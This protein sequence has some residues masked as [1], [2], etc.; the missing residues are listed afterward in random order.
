M[1]KI[2][3]LITAFV[4]IMSSL[5]FSASASKKVSAMWVCTVKNLDFPSKQGLSAAELKSE[6]ET[7]IDSAKSNGINTLFF[8]VRP[9]ADALYKSDIFPW[10]AV[11]S[12]TQ[13]KAPADNFDPLSYL[14]EI[15]HN[16]GIKVHA[17]INPYRIGTGGVEE[18][19]SALSDNNP[20]VL[21]PEYRVECSDGGVYF[22]PALPEVRTLIINGVLEIVQNYNVD[23]IHFDD[24]FY[25]YNVSDYP[26]S[27]DYEKYGADFDS[28]EDFRRNNI[29]T[30]VRDVYKAIKS[31]NPKVQFGI[32]P[33]GI[34]DNK[35]DNPDGSD[36]SGMSSYRSIYSDS[37]LWVQNGWLDYIC[38]QIYW[39]F[40]NPV[41][42]F[43]TLC[44]WWSELCSKTD[45]ELYIGIALYKVGTDEAGFENV[46][47]ITRQL[48]YLDGLSAVS[49]YSF[50]RS[51]NL[52]LLS[53][54]QYTPTNAY[55][56]TTLTITS[57]ENGYKTSSSDC[58]VSGV[59]DPGKKLTVNGKD[60]NMTLHGYFSVY[61]P[62]SVGSNEFTFLNGDIT[63][64][65]TIIRT[66]DTSAPPEMYNTC[67]EKDSAFPQGKCKF[68]SG[69]SVTFSVNALKDADVYAK[70]GDK[71]VQLTKTKETD[72]LA[73]F[74]ASVDIPLTAVG[75]MNAGKVVFYTDFKGG[76]FEYEAG[77]ITVLTSDIPLY[78]LS[79][80]YVYD[81]VDGGSMMDNFQLSASSEVSATAYA[82]GMYRLTSGKWISED[83]VSF[84]RT[85]ANSI[86][87][88]TS[89]YIKTELTFTDMPTYNSYVTDGGTLVLELYGVSAVPKI[90]GDITPD[91]IQNGV[92]ATALFK[93]D[94]GITGYYITQT[95]GNTLTVYI[96]NNRQNGI[97]GK[98]I[99]ID[100]GHGG[101]DCGAIGPA[102]KEGVCESE[103]NLSLSFVLKKKLESL[104]AEVYLTRTDDT[105]LTL[106]ERVKL[107]RSY[108]PD[109]CISLHHNSVEQISD[110]CKASGT[111][112]LYS[113]Q[114]S[115][116]LARQIEKSFSNGMPIQ[117]EGARAQSLALCRDYRY[118]CVLAECGYVCNP[119]E[120]ELI[121]TDSYKNTVCENIS[122][123]VTEY[124]K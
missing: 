15:A 63:Q 117:S 80:C 62:L 46:S 90:K 33:F 60:V 96:Y 16:A 37:R 19:M 122:K 124:F 52:N 20:A 77:E 58:S 100:A 12:G 69:E 110:F 106:D 50:F 121:L 84:T 93:K 108:S 83:N 59:A 43:K 118:P 78:T 39:S 29:N 11:I 104:G 88:D 75:N 82:K 116:P 24:Y 51:G 21:H 71:T 92:G 22:N 53:D 8:Q 10:S 119:S 42:P 120:Y 113:R 74:S 57:P 112:M 28:I 91:I 64:K 18:V 67:F 9:S 23:G 79:E 54:G 35:R 1:K 49:G 89:K 48:D 109:M 107:I 45:T 27:E 44:D 40:E 86:E 5:N 30:L 38:P 102:G 73:T 26:D 17:W 7:V 34:W 13:G 25:P 65:I 81:S 41:A 4:L 36:T 103:L 66:D 85:D 99:V 123:A 68:Y 47:Q 72:G 6:L 76:R 97:S 101:E 55:T 70:L 98:T 56:S 61:L 31:V 32:S 3:C 95:D 105:K 114:T 87:I 94:E 2:L 115:L 14:T 111:L